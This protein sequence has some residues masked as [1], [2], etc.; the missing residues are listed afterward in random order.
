[1]MHTIEIVYSDGSRATWNV[2]DDL[3]DSIQKIENLLINIVGQ[4]DSIRC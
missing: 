3:D 4:P 1:M 2:E